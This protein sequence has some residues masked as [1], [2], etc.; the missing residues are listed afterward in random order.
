MSDWWKGYWWG[1]GPFMAVTALNHIFTEND[2]YSA[3][4]FLRQIFG[5]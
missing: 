2:G 1:A 4:V 3:G 5:F